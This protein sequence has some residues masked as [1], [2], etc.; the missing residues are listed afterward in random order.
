M[1]KDIEK[2]E[3]YLRDFFNYAPVG[4]HVFGPDR[5]IVDINQAE[6]DM[7]GYQREE[8]VGKKKW[9]DLILP[10]Q[11]NMFKQHWKILSKGEK[12]SHYNYTL[13]HKSG[14]LV[15]VVLYAT[16]RFNDQGKIIN[17]R[18]IVVDVTPRKEIEKSLK[19]S[20]QTIKEQQS[21]FK[22]KSLA[23][24]DILTK[25]EIEKRKMKQ[26]I[27]T[28]MENCIFPVLKQLK[29]KLS[30][31]NQRKINVIENNLQQLTSAFGEKI[32]DYRIKL[33]PREIEI[34]NMVK[35]GFSTHEIAEDL[36]V[37]L[38]TVENHRNHLRKKL[39]ISKKKVSLS[40]YL[41]S[42]E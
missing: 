34:A 15:Y 3:Q 27:F 36:S 22:E 39:N 7:V 12:V 10:D 40:S 6:L 9:S 16:A 38:R 23:L 42:L 19:I 8:I 11:K 41:Q 28:N 4:F 2:N 25:I 37:S 1:W 21:A 13:K 32:S 31:T 5:L 33:T 30:S 29:R 20:K 14:V 35:N 17:T 24:N 18:G 26:N